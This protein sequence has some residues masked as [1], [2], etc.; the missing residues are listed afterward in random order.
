MYQSTFAPNSQWS[1]EYAQGPEIRAYWQRVA[2]EQNVHRFIK[3]NTKVQEARWNPDESKWVLTIKENSSQQIDTVKY[4]VVITAVGRFN[5]WRLPDYPGINE[6][7]GHLR[8]SSN[9]DPN[10]DPKGKTVA[11]IGNGASGVQVVPELQKVVKHLDHY[12]RSPTWIAGSLGGRDRQSEPMRFAPEQVE[13][14]KD[15]VKYLAYRKSVEETYWRRFGG[16]LKGS[17]ENSTARDDYKAAMAK[18][19]GSKSELLDAITPEFSPNCRRLT[20]GPGYLEALTKENVNFIQT[21]IKRFTKDGIETVDGIHRPVEA[22]I[23]STGAN[24]DYAFPF[25]IISGDTDLSSAWKPEGK[26]GGPYTYLGIAAPGFPNLF[27]IHGPN[28]TGHSGT[29]PHSGENQVTYLAKVLRK[30]SG[31]GLSSIAPTE[32]AA[33]DFVEY[34]DAFFPRTVLTEDCRSWTNSKSFIRSYRQ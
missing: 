33:D 5:A 8:H 31:E 25:S 22:I 1:E 18:R 30:I 19:L 11:V 20:P 16:I 7:Q 9:W 29:L 4:D 12:A 6:Y 24:V 13:D 23:C 14:F 15:P 32:A 10:F 27:F 34:C 2:T 17:K 26:L 3:F 21:A 28:S